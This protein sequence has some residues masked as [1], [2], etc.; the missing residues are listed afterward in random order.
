MKPNHL[1]IFIPNIKRIPATI[2][3]VILASQIAEKDL[4]NHIC[5]ASLNFSHFLNSS[6][7]L[8]KMMIFASIAIPIESTNHAIDARVKTIPNCFNIASV[9][10]IY[11]NNASA[12]ITHDNL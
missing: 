3:P 4:S 8:S 9:I 10:A 11:I 6:F 2:N 5:T 1:I 12:A 7:I